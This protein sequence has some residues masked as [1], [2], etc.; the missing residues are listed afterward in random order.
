MMSKSQYRSHTMDWKLEVSEK[1]HGEGIEVTERV[2]CQL[3]VP[4]SI[5]PMR[6]CWKRHNLME[7]SIKELEEHHR[8]KVIMWLLGSSWAYLSN[9]GISEGNL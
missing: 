3:N 7:S 5:G 6:V 9:F 8:W 1:I 2:L 4:F